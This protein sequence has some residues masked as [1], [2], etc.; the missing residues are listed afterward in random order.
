MEYLISNI[1]CF[2]IIAVLV[3]SVK[4]QNINNDNT[5]KSFLLFAYMVLGY[6]ATDFLCEF[7]DG[8][9]QYNTIAYIINLL[10]F[11]WIDAI[12]IAFSRYLSTLLGRLSKKWKY[13]MNPGVFFTYLRIPL[14]IVL[15]CLGKLF[16]IDANGVYSDGALS[17][18][19]YGMSIAV[20]LMLVAVV[21][22]NRK[23][24]TLKQ[25]LVML[26]YLIVPTAFSIVSIITDA[27]LFTSI[28][29]TVS[30][31]VIYTMVQSGII[32]DFRVRE[33]VL[34]EISATDLLTGLG[35]R[36]AYYNRFAALEPQKNVGVV[37]C[38]LNGLKH[39]NDTYGHSEGD[40]LIIRFA[41]ML[42]AIFDSKD[43]FRISGDEFVVLIPAA[44]QNSFAKKLDDLSKTVVENNSIAAVGSAFGTG[45]CVEQLVSVAESAMYADK[46]EYYS[47]SNIQR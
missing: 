42:Q 38:D 30:V 25:L 33:S 47:K 29:I 7:F 11:F 1:I 6:L 43:I 5:T 12:V 37:F 18:I 26:F 10:A 40:K 46:R 21:I 14:E 4:L 20:M 15:A 19:P 34:E 24:L 16:V 45:C 39:T 13:V 36:R 3:V 32:E 31:L 22:N 23:Y 41:A 44:P 27:Y 17:S 35:N 2:I 8:K 9:P 28:S